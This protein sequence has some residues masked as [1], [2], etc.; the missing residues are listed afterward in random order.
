MFRR[1]G[2]FAYQLAVVVDDAAQH[3]TQVVRGADLLD[4]TPQQLLLF[5]LLGLSPPAY[6]HVPVLADRTGQKLSKQ[7][8]ATAVRNDTAGE[9]LHSILDLLGQCPPPTLYRARPHEVLQWA[10]EHWEIDAVPHGATNPRFV[11]V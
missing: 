7:T 2:F 1:D 6:Y 9:N 8:A 3:V 11:C 10:V 4:N 5:E